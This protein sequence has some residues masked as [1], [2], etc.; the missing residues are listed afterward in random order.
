MHDSTNRGKSPLIEDAAMK[1]KLEM[2]RRRSEFLG[3]QLEELDEYKKLQEG[4]SEA[5]CVMI[6]RPRISAAV[7]EQT[8][9]DVS[10]T[11]S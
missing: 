6:Y 10:G 1:N 4:K 7:S 5:L 9:D 11:G 3:I 8:E 2:L